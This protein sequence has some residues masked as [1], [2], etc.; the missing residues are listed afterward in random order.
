[1]GYSF[2]RGSSEDSTGLTAAAVAAFLRAGRDHRRGEAESRV[3]GRVRRQ[4]WKMLEP[5]IFT[6]Y[7]LSVADVSKGLLLSLLSNFRT[8]S[9]RNLGAHIIEIR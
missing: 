7:E 9:T 6:G 2:G 3:G 8:D 5:N 1:M 4:A